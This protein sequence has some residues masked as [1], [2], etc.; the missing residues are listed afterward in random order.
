MGIWQLKERKAL[1]QHLLS[2]PW[3][4]ARGIAAILILTPASVSGRH[5]PQ[6]SGWS[7]QTATLLR[8]PS[9][10]LFHQ[11]R[12]SLSSVKKVFLLVIKDPNSQSIAGCIAGDTGSCLSY[13]L[14]FISS[15]LVHKSWNEMTGTFAK[16]QICKFWPLN[17]RGI[18]M[19]FLVRR[20][21]G[22]ACR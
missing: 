10:H 22:R 6:H 19:H 3:D 9:V 8:I 18:M 20:R 12:C 7:S 5:T 16:Y 4:L 17:T 2:Q 13:I 1:P 15:L 11:T 14:S 21:A